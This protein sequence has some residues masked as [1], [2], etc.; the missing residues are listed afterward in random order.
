MSSSLQ[1]AIKWFDELAP[2]LQTTGRLHWQNIKAELA[3]LSH[4]SDYT[5]ALEVELKQMFGEETF[6][7][8]DKIIHEISTRL[9]S[10]IK[11]AQN[12][13]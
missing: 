11:A 1:S 13:A 4:N 3:Q 7:F 8:S 12:C 9:N 2:T 10:V 5:L 6:S